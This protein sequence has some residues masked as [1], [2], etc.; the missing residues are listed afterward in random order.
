MSETVTCD[1]CHKAV[2]ASEDLVKIEAVTFTAAK[3]PGGMLDTPWGTSTA[4]ERLDFHAACWPKAKAALSQQPA[5]P[6]PHPGH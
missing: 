3:Q 4:S 6:P 5:P 1:Y 2:A